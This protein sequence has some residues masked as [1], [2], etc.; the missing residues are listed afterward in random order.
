MHKSFTPQGP[1][2]VAINDVPIPNADHLEY[3]GLTIS[4]DMKWKTHI[5]NITKK[6]NC[7]RHFSDT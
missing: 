2:S 5:A 1:H 3:L 4:H 6:A 7:Q